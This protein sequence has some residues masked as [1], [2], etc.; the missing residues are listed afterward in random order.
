MKEVI[1]WEVSVFYTFFK[2][3]LDFFLYERKTA[4]LCTSKTPPLVY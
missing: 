2:K 3:I 4:Y 1:F